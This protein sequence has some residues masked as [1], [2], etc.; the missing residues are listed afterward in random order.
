MR[1]RYQ[2]ILLLL[3]LFNDCVS[4]RIVQENKSD[5]YFIGGINQPL[6]NPV[7]VNGTF[8]SAALFS[9]MGNSYSFELQYVHRIFK[10][11]YLGGSV[12]QTSFSG[13]RRSDLS[14]YSGTVATAY[15]VSPVVMFKTT[16]FRSRSFN[17]LNFLASVLPGMSRV[18][19]KTAHQSTING[20]GTQTPF[21]SNAMGFGIELRCGLNII[22]K[23]SVGINISAGYQ[24]L[25]V[26]SLLYQEKQIRFLNLKAGLFYRLNK[27]K[28]YRYSGL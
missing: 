15:S 28:K 6:G 7:I 2:L 18:N 24:D 26:N 14:T 22:V 17:K 5:I 13:W 8:N 27:D 19:V 25:F 9:N 11:I 23:S 16:I 4:Q 1:M 20:D 3:V 12:D 10:K 21:E